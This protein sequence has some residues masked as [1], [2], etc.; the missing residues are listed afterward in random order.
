MTH[1]PGVRRTVQI[2]SHAA[3]EP[4]PWRNRQVV[5]VDVIR[6]ATTA[7][8][9][10]E[11][12]HRCF[13][14]GSVLHARRLAARLGESILA[15]EVGGA[16]VPGFDMG[17]SPVAVAALPNDDR[18]LILLSSSGTAIS[19]AASKSNRTYRGC[20]RNDRVVASA[21]ASGPDSVLLVGA[22]TRG[23]FRGEDQF[24]CSRIAEVLMEAGFEPR[25]RTEE[26][27]DRWA[28][29]SV[30]DAL[31]GGSARFLE[32]SNQLQ[33]LEFIRFHVDDLRMLF[34][35]DA[36]GPEVIRIPSGETALRVA[37]GDRPGR[38]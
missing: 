12:G 3:A 2:L 27:V 18:P 28:G 13:L 30:E 11:M 7:V 22:E 37:Q 24:C 36:D 35:V 19:A 14:A 9:A 26:V 23:E 5:V 38:P 10:V 25:G 6:S 16:P 33:D 15:G 21:L 34:V 4:V 1:R 32:R 31:L 17:N 8:T 29:A 20:L